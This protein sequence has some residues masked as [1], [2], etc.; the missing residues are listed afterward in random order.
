MLGENDP[1]ATV[2]VRDVKVAREFYE[3]KLGLTLEQNRQGEAFSYKAGTTKLLVYRSSEAGSNTA[4]AVT[5]Y[6]RGKVDE[7]VRDLKAK[8]VNFEHYDMP[9][10]KLEGD[11]HVSGEMRVAWFKDPDGN[12]HALVSD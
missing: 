6:V 9:H 1:V 3:G 8:G 4:T 11:V 5:W 7:T 2:A 10:T 12:I